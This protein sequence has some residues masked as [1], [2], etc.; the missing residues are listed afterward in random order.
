MKQLCQLNVINNQKISTNVK[1]LIDNN[2]LIW[3]ILIN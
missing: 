2:F 1:N 3:Y